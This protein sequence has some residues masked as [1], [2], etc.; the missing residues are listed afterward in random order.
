MRSRPLVHALTPPAGHGPG[1]LRPGWIRPWPIPAPSPDPACCACCPAL[2]HGP[3]VLAAAGQPGPGV[4][5]LRIPGGRGC[6]R[7]AK[8]SRTRTS[9]LHTGRL[10]VGGRGLNGRAL[11]WNLL[12]GGTLAGNSRYEQ[13]ILTPGRRGW[14]WPGVPA[15]TLGL[16]FSSRH[17]WR[18]ANRFMDDSLRLPRLGVRPVGLQYA[19]EYLGEFSRQRGQ[20]PRLPRNGEPEDTR[21]VRGELAGHPARRHACAGLRRDPGLRAGGQPGLRPVTQPGRGGTVTGALPWQGQPAWRAAAP[22]AGWACALAGERTGQACAPAE[23]HLLEARFGSDWSEW[24]RR[25]LF[26]RHYLAAWSWSP[27]SVLGPAPA[28]RGCLAASWTSRMWITS[29]PCWRAP[30]CAARPLELAEG[31]GR[32]GCAS[33][34]ALDL[35][36]SLDAGLKQSVRWGDGIDVRL[37]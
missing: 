19:N 4:R 18:E 37:K 25:D 31:H 34:L 1:G 20:S 32:T 10:L 12:L 35:Q 16:T 21:F 2:H 23:H 6:P 7:W 8:G 13:R 15:P 36:A 14:T 9:V 11:R 28:G 17:G 29:G 22:L 33:C 27:G 3:G 26:R 24:Q 30:G 5:P